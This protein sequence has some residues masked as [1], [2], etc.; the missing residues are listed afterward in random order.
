MRIAMITGGASGIGLATAQRFVQDGMTV[1]IADLND[2]AAHQAAA[3]L[4]GTGHRG[5]GINIA[6]EASVVSAFD[7]VETSLGAVAVLACFAGMLSTSP[8]P[9]RIPLIEQTVQ[10]WDQVHAVNARGTFLCIRELARRRTA[11]PVEH[12]RIITVASLAAQVGGLQSGAAYTGSKGS[13]LSLTKLAAR[14]L[15]ALGI[16]V[17]CIA[18]GPIDTPMLRATVPE[19]SGSDVKYLGAAQIPLGRVGEPREIA[20]AAGYLASIDGGFVT[21]ATIDVNGGMRMQ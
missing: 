10:E 14:E 9:G 3:S 13:V 8:K 11:K 1:V 16:T 15:A 6:D 20:A 18:P 19:G 21:G 5:I 4:P 2:A 12:G 17:N 7:A